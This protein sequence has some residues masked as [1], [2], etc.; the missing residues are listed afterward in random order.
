VTVFR[1][2][3]DHVSEMIYPTLLLVTGILIVLGLGVYQRLSASGE[4]EVEHRGQRMDDE[5][6][7]PD[8]FKRK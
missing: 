3:K 6:P 8:R 4:R 1:V 7:P 5:P 2:R